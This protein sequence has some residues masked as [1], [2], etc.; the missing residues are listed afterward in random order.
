M[1][2]EIIL[3]SVIVIQAILHYIEGQKLQDRIMSRNLNE[4]MQRD[5]PAKTY[6]SA[7][8]RVLQKWRGSD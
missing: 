1:I 2:T 3:C 5:E 4:Y 6:Q 8:D 7:H